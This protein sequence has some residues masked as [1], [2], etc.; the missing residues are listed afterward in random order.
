MTNATCQTIAAT[1]CYAGDEVARFTQ[2]LFNSQM[3][4][5][6]SWVFAEVHEQHGD[7]HCCWAI[8]M[9]VGWYQLAKEQGPERCGAEGIPADP[10][11]N[12]DR[13]ALTIALNG[14]TELLTNG[15]LAR[16][17]YLIEDLAADARPNTAEHARLVNAWTAVTDE[18]GDRL[19]DAM[20]AARAERG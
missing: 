14:D 15:E 16:L 7:E 6:P 9:V 17:Q 11:L 20:E 13:E 18:I 5:S 12:A 10:S 19:L 8:E 1:N 4:D 2:M 3:G